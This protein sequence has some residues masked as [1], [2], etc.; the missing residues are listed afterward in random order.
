MDH[1]ARASLIGVTVGLASLAAASVAPAQISP[2]SQNRQ[3]VMSVELVEA[4]FGYGFGDFYYH[5]APDLNPFSDLNQ[6]EAADFAGQALAQVA[7]ESAITSTSITASANAYAQSEIF[8]PDW[9]SLADSY[10]ETDFVFQIT[11]TSDYQLSGTVTVAGDA[12]AFV[13]LWE[14]ENPN[15]VILDEVYSTGFTPFSFQGTLAPG[16]YR[17]QAIGAGYA[18]ASFG[19]FLQSDGT[20][21][22]EF[23]VDGGATAAPELAFGAESL[24][25]S[26]NPMRERGAIRYALPGSTPAVLEIF[27]VA[28]RRV[29]RWNESA[30]AGQIAWDGRGR[31]GARLPAGVYFVRLA[32]DERTQT[33]KLLLRR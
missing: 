33:K 25:I 10:T 21:D 5:E 18:Y 28:G 9:E 23:T 16:Q 8:E 30:P 17:L 3:V 22:F 15:S 32:N 4:N 13:T 2:V 7:Q 26:P 1:P 14:W 24:V 12:E 11:T 6:I 20:Y 19:D 31:N 27:D 29:A